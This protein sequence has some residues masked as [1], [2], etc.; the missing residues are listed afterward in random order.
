MRWRF[1]RLALVVLR[2]SRPRGLRYRP[3]RRT[4]LGG[5]MDATSIRAELSSRGRAAQFTCW[6]SFCRVTA[7]MSAART[8]QP[9]PSWPTGG[10]SR[11]G[12]SNSMKMPMLSAAPWTTPTRASGGF[13]GSEG[14]GG[15]GGAS[16]GAAAT[17]GG[18]GGRREAENSGR[19]RVS[20]RLSS[21]IAQS[22]LPTFGA[23]ALLIVEFAK[24]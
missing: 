24:L 21:G 13:S 3:G 4:A 5:A 12:P 14:G 7:R 15:G 19:S 11:T 8:T 1:R 2:G 18:A 22:G 23:P 6:L 20:R 17:T 9:W 16:T 10:G